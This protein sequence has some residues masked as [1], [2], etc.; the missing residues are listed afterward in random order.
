MLKNRLKILLPLL[1][2][3]MGAI[4]AWAIIALRPQMATQAPQKELPLVT[5]MQVEPQTMQLNVRSQGVVTPRHEIDLIPEVA[6][7]II[8]L[9]ANF[10]VGGFF[11]RNEVLLEIDPRDYDYA[12]VQA[13]AQISE[14]KRQLAM[15]EA[16]AEQARNEWDA[17]GEGAPTPL[18]MRKPQLAE[19]KAKL[20]AAEANLLQ[21]QIKR[22]RCVIR[23]P[24]SGRLQTKLTALGQVV[25]TGDKLAHLYATDVAEIR[26]PIATDQLAFLDLPLNEGVQATQRQAL[27]P[28]VLLSA[29]FAGALHTW[30]GQVVRTEGKLDES[31]GVM[32][33]VAEVSQPYKQTGNKPPLLNGLFVQAE[34]QGKEYQGIFSLPQIAVNAEHKV[35]LVDAKQQLHSQTVTILRA[36]SERV[37][38]RE[39]LQAGDWV[40]LSGVQ[41]PVE[42]MTVKVELTSPLASDGR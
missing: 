15:E 32:Y 31:T 24:F 33:A 7:K 26:L 12:L 36:E 23:A 19:A 5:V 21:A 18:A 37:L 2:L 34:V 9:H 25:Q 13:Q 10:V 41:I 1:L 11:A 30:Q 4:T 20:K 28:R 39:G 22:S 17:L 27:F 3:L 35:L 16:Q 6:G 40:V 29:E 8:K 42:G 38:I 14:A